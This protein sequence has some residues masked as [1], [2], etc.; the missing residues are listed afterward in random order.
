MA[1]I[2]VDAV[3]EKTYFGSFCCEIARDV[4]VFGSGAHPNVYELYGQVCLY[5]DCGD[6]TV[7][8]RDWDNDQRALMDRLVKW[9]DTELYRA[10]AARSAYPRRI[11]A[12][13]VHTNPPAAPITGGPNNP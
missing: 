6:A 1:K 12:W 13:Q 2:K 10:N 11:E 3:R 8:H 7:L 5:D 4:D 9:F